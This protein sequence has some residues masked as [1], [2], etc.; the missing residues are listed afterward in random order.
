MFDSQSIPES[1]PSSLL[2]NYVFCLMGLMARF[3][4]PAMYSSKKKKKKERDLNSCSFL[5][6]A[7]IHGLPSGSVVK[8]LPAKAGD[9]CLISGLG[10]S[11]VGRNGNHISLLTPQAGLRKSWWRLRISA[12]LPSWPAAMLKGVTCPGC[13]SALTPGQLTSPEI[14]GQPCRNPDFPASNSVDG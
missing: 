6:L 12:L 9:V 2:K 4:S 5:Y 14:S 7:L 3:W 11:P 13:L 1:N 8:N 10:R